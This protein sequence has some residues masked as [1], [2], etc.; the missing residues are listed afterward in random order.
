MSDVVALLDGER[1]QRIQA[2]REKQKDNNE[3]SYNQSH[4]ASA[5]SIMAGYC[6]IRRKTFATFNVTVVTLP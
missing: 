2:G 5:G 3:R 1:E 6:T 4:W